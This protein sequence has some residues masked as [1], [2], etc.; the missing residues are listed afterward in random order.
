[1]DKMPTSTASLLQETL[2]KTSTKPYNPFEHIDDPVIQEQ[3]KILKGEDFQCHMAF[4]R[5]YLPTV[6]GPK[7]WWEKNKQELTPQELWFRN[8]PMSPAYGV[9]ES[10]FES[11]RRDRGARAGPAKTRTQ[12]WYES[13]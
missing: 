6:I 9:S 3:E 5:E 13:D 8:H 7:R 12:M 10:E 1:M 11:L 2:C 4:G